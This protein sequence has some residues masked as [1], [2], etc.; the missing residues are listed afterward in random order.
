MLSDSVRC[1]I[2]FVTCGKEL[3]LNMRSADIIGNRG[4]I[5]FSPRFVVCVTAG[6]MMVFLC[7][8][9]S[10]FATI[11]IF[12]DVT[13]K[14][15]YFTETGLDAFRAFMAFG[16]L[17]AFRVF[18]AFRAFI[19]NL[20]HS[21]F[22]RFLMV[23]LC[24]LLSVFS[25]VKQYEDLS[26]HILYHLAADLAINRSPGDY[27]LY[28]DH[29]ALWEMFMVLW[30][31]VE[32]IV[33]LWSAGC[34]FRY[35]DLSGRL[36]FARKPLCLVGSSGQVFATSALR[37]LR[38][39]QILRMVRVDRRGG[40]WKLLGSVIWAHRQVGTLIERCL[41]FSS[42]LVFLAEKEKNP[43][44]FGTYAD[45]L[46]WGVQ[47]Q[48]QKHL[49]RRRVPAAT[50]IQCLWRCYAA[51]ENSLSIATWKPHMRPCRSPTT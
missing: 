42:F 24:L 35:Q 21:H 11:P 1:Y 31:A 34:R 23:F 46:W 29:F 38:F 36:H 45:A 12:E 2:W 26:G 49:I 20:K 47:Q 17:T 3:A 9:L 5:S 16:G 4:S 39:F 40:S 32:Y 27:S 15:L 30:F 25:T 50:L 14:V 8:M 44:R 22:G 10:V 37:G 43:K 7:L 41:I 19:S 51:D 33:R 13:R 18:M 28:A 48:R 6:F